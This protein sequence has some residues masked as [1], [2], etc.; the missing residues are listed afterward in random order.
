MDWKW[1]K[2]ITYEEAVQNYK[3]LEKAYLKVELHEIA[4][5]R[6]EIVRCLISVNT[7]YKDRVIFKLLSISKELPPIIWMTCDKDVIMKGLLSMVKD[8]IAEANKY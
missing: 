3:E 7:M 6:E 8:Y 1:D 2:I 5:T 4:K